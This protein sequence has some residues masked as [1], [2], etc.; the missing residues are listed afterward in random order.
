[1]NVHGLFF[2]NFLLYL[3]DILPFFLGG[4]EYY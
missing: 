4:I 1:M 2:T 3:S